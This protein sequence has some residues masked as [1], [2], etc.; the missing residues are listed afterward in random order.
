MMQRRYRHEAKRTLPSPCAEGTLHRTK[1][2]FI[3]HAPQVRFIE[4]S[5]CFRKCFFLGSPC[6]E[7]KVKTIEYCFYQVFSSKQGIRRAENKRRLM[8]M[9]QERLRSRNQRQVRLT[10]RLISKNQGEDLYGI[11][12]LLRYGIRP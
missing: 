1:S 4:K 9:R 8:T 6:W 3:F 11:R 7:T 5:T 12:N 2:C 10:V